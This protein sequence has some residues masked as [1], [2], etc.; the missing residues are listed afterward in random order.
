MSNGVSM[1]YMVTAK[2]SR[3]A[4]WLGTN[5]QPV[6]PFLS[7][8]KQ[9]AG[10]TRHSNDAP[11]CDRSTN[12]TSQSNEETRASVCASRI[13]MHSAIGRVGGRVRPSS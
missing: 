11:P 1:P 5:V 8:R 2:E 4:N 6:A 12:Q 3:D 9:H 7:A 10:D 13:G